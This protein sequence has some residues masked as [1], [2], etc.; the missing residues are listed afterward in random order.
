MNE[1]IR[2]DGIDALGA[3]VFGLLIALLRPVACPGTR[4]GTGLGERPPAWPAQRVEAKLRQRGVSASA[5]VDL[6][7]SS[8]EA[9]PLSLAWSL[10][11]PARAAIESLELRSAAGHEPAGLCDRREARQWLDLARRSGMAGALLGEDAPGVVGLD[12]VAP[13]AAALHLRVRFGWC[14]AGEANLDLEV[15]CEAPMAGEQ[16]IRR[17]GRLLRL[18]GGHRL[19]HLFGIVGEGEAVRISDVAPTAT[20]APLAPPSRP[21]LFATCD[22]VDGSGALYRGSLAGR[23]VRLWAELHCGGDAADACASDGVLERPAVAEGSPQRCDGRGLP[24]PAGQLPVGLAGE[25]WP[26]TSFVAVLGSRAP[27]GDK[28]FAAA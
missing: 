10:P 20:A 15:R 5:Q 17:G 1:A 14:V 25:A 3:Q 2:Q 19:D 12:L 26:A 9:S 4:G 23:A 16:E 27:N 24:S 13:A 22:R 18:G 8:R 28:V 21:D 6:W 7:L 11:L